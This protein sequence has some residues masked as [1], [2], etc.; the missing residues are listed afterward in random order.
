MRRPCHD[1]KKPHPKKPRRRS[2]RLQGFDYTQQ[3]AFFVTI[4]TENRGCLF[5]E[6]VNCGMR[7][8]DAGR[9]ALLVWE[10]IPVHFP[11]VE[12]D[13]T[14]VMPNHL[15]G[16]IVIASDPM[17]ATHA[18]PLPPNGSGPAR[19][20]IGAIVGS[21]KSAVSKRIN[22]MRGTPGMTIWQRNYYE[23]VI[24]DEGSLTK[25]RQYIMD[26]PERWDEDHENPENQGGQRSS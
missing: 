15:H 3:G 14:V 4:C 10:D 17:R 22:L 13:A 5:G 9:V 11:H 21:Y 20:S 26:N 6:I 25:I 2:I 18:S 1:P 16:V 12:L 19:C 7:L 8:N 23:H 24:R